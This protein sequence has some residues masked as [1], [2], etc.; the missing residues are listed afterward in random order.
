M[1]TVTL[2]RFSTA[3]T[4]ALILPVCSSVYFSQPFGPKID[5]KRFYAQRKNDANQEKYKKKRNLFMKGSVRGLFIILFLV[6]MFCRNVY[7]IP[8]G[9]TFEGA[10]NGQRDGAGILSQQ[11]LG[12]GSSLSYSICHQY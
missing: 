1:L 6:S 9:Y 7:A 12:I 4:V 8:M 11:G 5:R 10:I 3:S 2:L